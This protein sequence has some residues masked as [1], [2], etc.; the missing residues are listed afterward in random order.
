MCA[1]LSVL[2]CLL[3][4]ADGYLLSALAHSA[5]VA[6]YVF[7]FD[8]RT[9]LLAMILWIVCLYARPVTGDGAETVDAPSRSVKNA[10]P[11]YKVKF[12][13]LEGEDIL[14][15]I[16]QAQQLKKQILDDQ[17]ENK[18]LKEI[19]K[20]SI[21]FLERIGGAIHLSDKFKKILNSKK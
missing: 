17:K 5:Q 6:H 16:E 12:V 18:Q 20:E 14:W 21:P 8:S 10:A 9:V 3:T 19:A 11:R 13:S 7:V 4:A 1:L 2:C 15:T